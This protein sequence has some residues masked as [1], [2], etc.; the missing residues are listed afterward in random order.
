MG[1]YGLYYATVMQSV[2]LVALANRGVGIP[3]DAVTP[4]G[5]AV[6][7]AF[8]SVVADTEYYR[9]WID[10]HDERVPREVVA[11]YGQRACFCRLREPDAVDRQLLVT[12]FFIW[13]TPRRHPFGAGRCNSC[14]SFLHRQPLRRLTSHLSGGWS[15]TE[16]IMAKMT[17]R[18]R[19]SFRRNPR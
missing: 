15:I 5:R 10:R 12:R 16:P 14:V 19:P 9:R 4:D 11:E 7:E 13:G 18:D 8:R 17:R 2:G 6:A 1:G 3:V